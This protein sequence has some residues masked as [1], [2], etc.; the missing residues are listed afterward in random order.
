M[1]DVRSVL[2]LGS[3][4]FIGTRLTQKLRDAGFRVRLTTH[5]TRPAADAIRVDY[6]TDHSVGTWLPRLAGIDIVINA[7]GIFVEQGPRTFRALH[8]TAPVAVFEACA[9][10]GVQHVV[11][12]SALGADTG[13][14][15]YFRSKRR[16][17]EYLMGLPLRWTIIQPSLVYGEQGRSSHLFRVLASMP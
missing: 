15:E 14:T 5:G 12:I 11:Q 13:T 2:V 9:H 3:T 10:A 6:T 8:T 1:A 16:A 7:V 17:D 4:G